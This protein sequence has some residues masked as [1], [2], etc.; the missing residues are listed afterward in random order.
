MIDPEK[1][2][3]ALRIFH[4]SRTM[5][6]IQ[7]ADLLECSAPTVRNR[8]KSWGA[9]TS[10]NKNGR[11]YA[12]PNVATFDKN[13]LWKYKGV[14][15]SRYGTLK[16]TVRHLVRSSLMGLDAAE[17]GRLIGLLPRSFMAQ[18]LTIPGVHRDKYEKRF[19]YFSDEEQTYRSQRTL[20]TEESKNKPRQLPSDADAIFILVDR[21]KH[22]ES[23][24]EQYAQRL[25][26]KG[27]SI[28]VVAIRKLLAYH[29]IEK[30]LRIPRRPGTE[31][32]Y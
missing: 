15:F 22:P 19:V 32:T 8:L 27:K 2:N 1:E 5:T 7:L 3:K 24:V 29:G 17:I 20:R 31:R 12:L 21:I 13:G 18:L 14:F 6:V 4:R 9:L 10:Y 26:R 30:K 28:S 25:R 16:R 11:Y 23:S